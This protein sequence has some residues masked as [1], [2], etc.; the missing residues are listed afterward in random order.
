MGYYLA[1]DPGKTTGWATFDEKGT[2]T[3]FDEIRGE[4]DFLDWLEAKVDTECPLVAVI[5]RYRSRPG[6]INSFSDM[7]TSRHIGAIER[8]LRK[9]KVKMVM[10]DPSPALAMGLRFISMHT[11]Y[12]GKHVPDKI[13]AVAH[14][15]YY[16]RKEGIQK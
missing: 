6:S 3:E 2:L 13:S 12:R 10:Q 8:I 4:D 9:R 7:P 5:E 11:M 14:G 15:T 16:L 1:I